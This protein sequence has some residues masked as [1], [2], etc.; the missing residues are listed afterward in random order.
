MANNPVVEQPAVPGRKRILVLILVGVVILAAVVGCVLW[1]R[2]RAE[3]R[4]WLTF[5]GNIDIREIQLAF[6]DEGRI[7]RMLVQEGDRI[8]KGQ[9]LAELDISRLEDAVR[10]AEATVRVDQAALE[11]AEITYRRTEA[12]A[13]DLY[14]SLQDRDNAIAA[15]KEAR[16]RLKADEAALVLARRQL[17][18]GK[19]VAPKDGVIEVRI[20]EPGDMVTPQAPV[21]TVALDNPIWAR[22]YVPEPDLGKIFPGMRAEIYTDSYPGRAF[23]G[24]IGYIS[25]T[26]EFTPKS[27]ETPQ[28]RTR[29]VYEVRVY[30]CNPDYRLRLGM[31]A[32]VKIRR[33]Q[34]Y[35][36]PPPPC[37]TE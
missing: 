24:W 22:I 5:Y 36:P 17:H 9:V 6:Y 7:E 32:T 35:P 28:L 30:A 37:S 27:V 26:A 18:D 16:D 1:L 34:P 15:L 19:L 21:F 20:L 3:A 12:L 2:A 13:K 29:L 31:P 23:P 25:P 33:S 10:K 11:N 14:V 4:E 8:K